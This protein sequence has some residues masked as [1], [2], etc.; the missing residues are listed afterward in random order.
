VVCVVAAEGVRET[1]GKYWSQR[2]PGVTVV[3]DRYSASATGS[4]PN[5]KKEVGRIGLGCWI[6]GVKLDPSLL[7][8][9]V[10]YGFR[11]YV[12]SGLRQTQKMSLFRFFSLVRVDSETMLPSRL[13]R[14]L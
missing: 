2:V 7:S 9:D 5:R 12:I 1:P 4:A 13:E 11:P 6:L 8:L 3:P 14:G 10:V